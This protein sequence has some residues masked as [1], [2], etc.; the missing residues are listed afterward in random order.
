MEVM[1]KEVHR[2]QSKDRRWGRVSRVWLIG[3]ARQSV[4]TSCGSAPAGCC[5]NRL[6]EPINKDGACAKGWEKGLNNEPPAETKKKNNNYKL[7]QITLR[8]IHFSHITDD[9]PNPPKILFNTV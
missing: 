9:G 1:A 3:R 7:F 6:M 5:L 8:E 4:T 2:C